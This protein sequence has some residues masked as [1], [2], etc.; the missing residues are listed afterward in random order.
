[1]AALKSPGA[2][3]FRAAVLAARLAVHLPQVPPQEGGHDDHHRVAGTPLGGTAAVL[4]PLV[5]ANE[6]VLLFTRR[7]EALVRHAGQVSFPGGRVEIQDASPRHTALRETAEEIGLVP[8]RVAVAGYLSRYR[9][10]TGFD[11]QP[12]VGVIDPGFVLTPNPAEVAAVFEVPLSFLADPANRV[13]A[14]RELNGGIRSFYTYTYDGHEIWGATA[15]II[16]DLVTRLAA[17]ESP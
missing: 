2:S 4:L 12:L 1:M 9:T 3:E 17:I 10:G 15:A 16:V 8:E 11:I 13:R 5:A 6:P 7:T 14:T